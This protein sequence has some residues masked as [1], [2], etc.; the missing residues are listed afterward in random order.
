MRL[1]A[2][3]SRMY[4]RMASETCTPLTA[5]SSAS[6]SDRVER[7]TERVHG[8]RRTDA[9]QEA[10]L[11]GPARIPQRQTKQETIAL[12]LREWRR[13]RGVVRVLGGEDHEGSWQEHRGAVRGDLTLL[14]R[15]EEC[16]LRP[17]R[18][19]VQLVGHQHVGEDRARTERRLAAFPVQHHRSRHVRRQEVGGELHTVEVEPEGAGE[20]LCEGGLAQSREVLHQKVALGEQAPHGELHHVVVGVQDALHRLHDPGVE[21]TERSSR[22]GRQHRPLGAPSVPVLHRG[23]HR[24][25]TTGT[26]NPWPARARG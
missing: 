11:V 5:P 16:G 8:S 17:C 20:R 6:R 10:V 4:A 14:H 21:R 22:L 12:T 26:P 18:G 3:M 13:S 15:L 24:T 25:L 7:G 1:A 23:R 2:T 19:P 9:R